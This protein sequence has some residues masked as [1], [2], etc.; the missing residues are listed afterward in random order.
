AADE[1][2]FRRPHGDAAVAD[3]TAGIARAPQIAADVTAHAVRPALHAV[4]HE[5]AEQLLI[6]ELVIGADVEHMHV[7]LAAG[8]AVAR[9]LAGRDDVQLLVVGREREPVGIGH[10]LLAD[11]EIDAPARIDAVAV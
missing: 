9:P 8:A 5:I 1:L 6:G 2:A 7:A 11:D 3:R 10:L 4:D